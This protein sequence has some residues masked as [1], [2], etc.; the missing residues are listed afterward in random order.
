[1]GV[2]RSTVTFLEQEMGVPAEDVAGP[3]IQIAFQAV[4]APGIEVFTRLAILV[5]DDGRGA[6][7]AV[8]AGGMLMKITGLGLLQ[9]GG[10]KLVTP[11][12][13]P[14]GDFGAPE[15]AQAWTRTSVVAVLSGR[16]SS[17]SSAR[18]AQSRVPGRSLASV[19]LGQVAVGHGEFGRVRAVE[20]LYRELGMLPG[21]VVV[22]GEP[23]QAG[24]PAVGFSGVASVAGGVPDAE[25][26]L[27][28]FK[29][30]NHE[31]GEVARSEQSQEVRQALGRKPGGMA[32][33]ALVLGGGLPV[34][35]ERGRFLC[36]QRV[37]Q[38][39]RVNVRRGFGMMSQPRVAG[40]RQRA[41]AVQE[42]RRIWRWIERRRRPGICSATAS[43]ASSWRKVMTLPV[44]RSMPWDMGSSAA[45]SAS[46]D[47]ASSR[48][49]STR[50][51]A[52]AIRSS[53][54]LAASG[55]R[56][57]RAITASRTVAGVRR[58]GR[59][60]LGDEE[61]VAAGHPEQLRGVDGRHVRVGVPRR[62]AWPA[63]RR[64]P[65]TVAP[66]PVV[67]RPRR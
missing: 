35:P 60:H 3:G 47:R 11:D 61:R 33:D 12:G 22:P 24:Q 21:P 50:G 9:A 59:E 67:G 30:V 20:R 31:V 57:T 44:S 37:V 45:L 41:R 14:G 58:A 18:Q 48:L 32:Q 43:R 28:G 6:E 13:V 56:A 2:R 52:K 46:M 49:I 54:L 8:R 4:F 27:T 62:G 23:V 25:G 1:M 42:G 40:D 10:E 17:T 26:F 65:V 66:G 64:P 7:V 34:R 55:S 63:T 29:R 15:V 16:R 36:G 53:T 39:H 5:P 38:Q 51:P 19:Q